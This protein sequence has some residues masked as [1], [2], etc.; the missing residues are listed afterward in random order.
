M[1]N[2][3]NLLIVEDNDGQIKSWETAI[4]LF[5][6]NKSKNEI[7]IIK[8]ETRK[9][10]KDGLDAISSGRFDAAVV[11]LKLSPRS[12]KS[13][14]NKIIA[15]I[16]KKQRFPIFVVSGFPQDLEETDEQENPFFKV[17]NRDQKF[18]KEILNEIVSIY[19]TGITKLLGKGEDGLISSI[20]NSLQK[21]FWSHMSHS[22]D[23]ISDSPLDTKKVLMRYALTHLIE[24]LSANEVVSN[25]PYYPGEMYV[26][27]PINNHL[28]TGVLLEEKVSGLL[29]IILMPSCD[30]VLRENG[31]RKAKKISLVQI[32]GIENISQSKNSGEIKKLLDN[33]FSLNYH[34]LPP[35][36]KFAGGF[37]NF[38][39]LNSV[40][41]KE[42]SDGFSIIGKVTAP[43]L[44][45]IISRFSSY[46]ARQGQPVLDIKLICEKIIAKKKQ[47]ASSGR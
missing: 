20:E 1:E 38:Q 7:P 33:N 47:S 40:M 3:L 29:F 32:E 43:F 45:D 19:N 41:E 6:R 27:P 24:Y 46:Y 36:K 2:C 23:E 11:D 10:L 25:E 21:I 18:F 30:M 5:N 34:F 9:N 13:E 17:Y 14:G 12:E 4:D 28:A 15:E 39:Y 26:L 16:K 44:K 35:F 22:F 42:I 31:S 8:P 37:I